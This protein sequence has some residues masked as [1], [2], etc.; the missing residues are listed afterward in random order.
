MV[1][2][3]DTNVVVSGLMWAG[4]PSKILEAARDE[5]IQLIATD[6]LIAELLDVLS[7]SKFERRLN[8]MGKTV[9][10]FMTNYRALVKLV[11]PAAIQPVSRDPDDDDILAC[12]VAGKADYIVTGDDDLLI[13][14]QYQGIQIVEVSQFLVHL[15]D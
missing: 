5:Q 2:I 6:V 11:E 7:R 13:L 9:E 8:A 12:A 3:L 15:M 4:P 14:E 10:A 1:V